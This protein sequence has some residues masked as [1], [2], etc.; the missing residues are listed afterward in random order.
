MLLSKRIGLILGLALFFVITAMPVPNELKPSAMKALAVV[1]LMAVWWITEAL[2]VYVTAFV[3]LALYPILGILT[4]SETAENYSHSF[5][6]MLLGGLIIAKAIEHQNLHKRIA[7]VSIKLMGSNKKN[8]VLSFMIATAFLSM[9]LANVAVALMML[10]I[11]LAVS[12]K[13]ESSVKNNSNTAKKF[14]IAL[15]LSVAY[16]A[17]IGGMASLIGTPPNLVFAGIISSLF[18]NAP[19]ITF[20]NWLVIGL[21]LVIV[22]LP[23]SWLFLIRYFKIEGS[24]SAGAEIINKE[25]LA[26][27]KITT[28]EKRV[29]AVFLL[30]AFGWIFRKDI[31]LGSFIIYGWTNILPLPHYINDTTIA[32]IGVLLMFITPSGKIE[33][34]KKE[35]LLNWKVAETVPWGVVMIVGGGYAI[36]KSFKV[37]GLAL[38]L[39]E[40]INIFSQLPVFFILWLVVFLITFLTEINSNT[41]TA[42]IILPILATMAVSSTIHPYLLMIPATF[43]CSCAFCMPSGTGPNAVIFSSEK[44]SIY[45]MAKAGIWMNLIAIIIITIIAYVIA[46]PYFGLSEL[47]NWIK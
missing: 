20:F 6:L 31:V 44:I 13:E 2:P 35:Y 7:L 46:V 24:I 9:W 21:P 43:A 42:N 36:A 12:T 47:P 45:E 8:I 25:H 38:W 4:A 33:N 18:P 3:P 15:M 5:V 22:I 27:G 10:P 34:G 1:A 16:A 37:T 14:S 29:L 19:E 26:L 23:I 32:F 40:Q 28:A 11:A 39:G 30:V 17:S 41:A